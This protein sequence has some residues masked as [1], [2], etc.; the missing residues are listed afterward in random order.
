MPKQLSPPCVWMDAGIV[1]YLLCDRDLRCEGC[2]FDRAVRRQGLKRRSSSN[3]VVTCGLR[4]PRLLKLDTHH[5]WVR[6]EPPNK[7]RVGL[8]SLAS[9][10]LARV[11]AVRLP[12]WLLAVGPN[13]PAAEII[14]RAGALR[15]PAPVRGRVLE[16][17]ERLLAH[18]S[19]LLH[20]PYGLG[21]MYCV[22]SPDPASATSALRSVEAA[23]LEQEVERALQLMIPG[24]L[25]FADGGAFEGRGLLARPRREHLR[26]LQEFLHL[27]VGTTPTEGRETRW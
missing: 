13:H 26:V 25:T 19:R 3:E 4:F 2:P 21:W 5:Q 17:N 24:P 23:W 14:A 15:F 6:F 1:D 18:P 20:D 12:S 27:G 22:A 16:V 9:S 8:D 10:L 11:R 7:L